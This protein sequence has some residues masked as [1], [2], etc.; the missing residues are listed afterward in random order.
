VGG[1]RES[2]KGRFRE[3]WGGPTL[4]RSK[5]RAGRPSPKNT[6]LGL[7]FCAAGRLA[8][9]KRSRGET[10]TYQ[11][12]LLPLAARSLAIHHFTALDPRFDRL[13]CVRML[14]L[15]AFSSRERTCCVPRSAPA[16][17]FDPGTRTRTVSFDHQFFVQPS[18]PFECV[19]VL[20]EPGE[21][22]DVSCGHRRRFGGVYTDLSTFFS[23]NSRKK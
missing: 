4:R 23:C 7:T 8:N 9:V 19:N 16:V 22:D 17:W 11:G 15:D 14:A 18:Y 6:I 10:K 21:C 2:A 13:L 20:S 1:V 5:K 12:S 3:S